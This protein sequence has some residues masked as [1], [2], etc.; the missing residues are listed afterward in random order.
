MPANNVTSIS[1]PCM[2]SSITNL[3]IASVA[4]QNGADV[5]YSAKSTIVG[6]SRTGRLPS[7]NGNPTFKSDYERMQYLC[8]KIGLGGSCGV[9][10]KTFS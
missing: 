4:Y 2:V 6:Q 8:G 5:I 1:C 3:V 10:P 9:P 7:P